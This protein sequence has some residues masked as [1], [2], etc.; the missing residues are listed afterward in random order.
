MDKMTYYVGRDNGGDDLEDVKL[1]IKFGVEKAQEATYW[2]PGFPAY[3]EILD[4]VDENGKTFELTEK[5]KE[6]FFEEFWRNV[7]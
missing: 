5:E 4:I 1:T 7:E 2:D 6:G 3:I